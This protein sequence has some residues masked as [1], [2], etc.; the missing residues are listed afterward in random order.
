MSNTESVLIVDDDEHILNNYDLV[1]RSDG[2]TNTLPERDSRNVMSLLAMSKMDLIIMDLIMPHIS[3]I[4]LISEITHW[5]PYIP[6]IIVS[7]VDEPATIMEC[8]SIGAHDYLVKP[9]DN[10]LFI[11][12]V[13]K[14]LKSKYH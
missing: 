6:V 9:V 3:G 14:A 7:A 4:E 5:H 8:I 11:S 10:R 1:L 13:K 12:T 2:F